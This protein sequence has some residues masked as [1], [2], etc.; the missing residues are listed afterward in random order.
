MNYNYHDSI[1]SDII[2]YIRENYT[3]AEIAE[4]IADRDEW[5]KQLNDDLWIC[6]SVTGNAS[7]SYY[8]NAYRAEESVCHNWDILEEALVEFGCS[9]INPI[10]RGAEWCD[11]TIRCYLLSE[12][13]S[14]ALDELEG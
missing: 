11:V 7:G 13:I 4:R 3:S 2:D 12:C 10:F 1:T 6:D 14:S 8:C 5:E 9:D